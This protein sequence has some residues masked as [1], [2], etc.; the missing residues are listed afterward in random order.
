MAVSAL[1]ARELDRLQEISSELSQLTTQPA[2]CSALVGWVNEL[3]QLDDCVVYTRLGN[4][5]TQMAAA[6]AKIDVN[7]K[8]RERIGLPIGVGIVG[9]SALSSEPTYVPDL[10]KDDRYI[11]DLS[12]GKSELSVPII[13]R[14]E[15]IGVLD[16]VSPEVDGFSTKNKQIMTSLAVLA[17][18]HLAALV[19]SA[20]GHAVDYG[21]VIADLANLRQSNLRTFYANITERAARALHAERV[22]LWLFNDAQ[23]AINCVDH[24]DLRSGDHSDGA[25][26]EKSAFPTYFESLHQERVIMANDAAKDQRTAEFAPIYLKENN[27]Q[28]MLDAPIR[29]SNEVIGVVCIEHTSE[30][31][32]WT[33][34]EASFVATLADFITIAHVSNEKTRAENALIQSQKMESLGRLAGGIAHDFNNLM[35]VISGAAETLQLKVPESDESANKLLGLIIDA[36]DRASRLTRNLMAYGGNQRLNLEALSTYELAENIRQLT[37][38]VVREEID[39]TFEL[40]EE[41]LWVRGDIT[42]LEQ[43]L[44]NLILNGIDAIESQGCIS[45]AFR[46]LENECVI[47]VLDDGAGMEKEIRQRIFDPFFTTKGDLGTGLGLSVCQGIIHQHKGQLTCESGIGLGTKFEL[48]LPLVAPPELSEEF[49]SPIRS[50]IERLPD[51]RIL[52]VEDEP[53]VRDVVKQMLEALGFDPIAALDTRDALEILKE[54]EIGLMISDVVMP[55]MRGPELYQEALLV[56][57]DLIALFISGYT[58]DILAEV[59]ED[60]P[61]MGY[62]SKPFTL[63]ELNVA[64]N[65]LLVAEAENLS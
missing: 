5:L 12:K 57:P 31:R 45:L 11:H 63:D 29:Y 23:T 36:R 40:P 26:L 49:D 14:G 56:K 32:E 1:N 33:N 3:T 7:G 51:T 46:Q 52:L 10:S 4:V 13:H 20:D 54:Q 44:L 64:L 43:V 59:P 6:G 9:T 60:H 48:R 65:G 55:D 50:V 8:I 22:N 47:T 19:T 37:E 34:D 27:I 17:A 39:L 42:S 25:V 53:G 38:N 18:P 62:L 61:R 58:E 41:D 30:M 16:A 24:F 35:T 28:S 21:E 2:L 15:V